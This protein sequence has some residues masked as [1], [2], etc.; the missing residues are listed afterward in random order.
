MA[1][2]PTGVGLGVI[3]IKL[4]SLVLDDYDQMETTPVQGKVI[5]K[6]LPDFL[7]HSGAGLIIPAWPVVAFL[8]DGEATITLMAT[9][10]IDIKPVNWQYRVTFDL[11]GMDPAPVY[12][13]VPTGSERNLS[14]IV[15]F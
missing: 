8:E 13:S 9:D 15:G 6:A 4:Y 5:F 12:I 14:D 10:D 3:H 7:T 1:A 11:E 2:L